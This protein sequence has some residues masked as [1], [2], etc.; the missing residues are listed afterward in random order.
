M[1]ILGI[2]T[3]AGRI[4]EKITLP[5]HYAKNASLLLKKNRINVDPMLVNIPTITLRGGV[6]GMLL[7]HLLVAVML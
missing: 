4:V 5:L 2:S 3:L 7:F 6:E 1:G